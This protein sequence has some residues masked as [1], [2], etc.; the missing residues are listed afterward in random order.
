MALAE[1]EVKQFVIHI[2][3]SYDVTLVNHLGEQ[4]EQGFDW[5]QEGA[6]ERS[7]PGL[8]QMRVLTMGKLVPRK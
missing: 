1:A 8:A 4:V 7:T 6:I 2:L 3:H 5:F